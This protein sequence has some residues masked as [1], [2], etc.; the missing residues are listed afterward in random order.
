[1]RPASRFNEFAA[2]AALPLILAATTAYAQSPSS[3]TAAPPRP[4]ATSSV[5][6]PAPSADMQAVLDAHKSL[7]P[8]PI[9]SLPPAEA[10]RQPTPADAV[11]VVMARQHRSTAP[12]PG[13]ST[14]D[15]MYPA[16]Q[17]MQK[18]RIYM[19]DA[20]GGKGPLPVIV[21][22]HGGGWVIAD[23]QAYDATPRF[24]CKALNA[25]VVSI[26]YRHAPEAK[27][28]AQ[29]DDANAAYE[30]VAKNAASWGGD[31]KRLALAGESAGGNLAVA[32]AVA[33]RDHGWPK[34]VHILSV[35]PIAQSDMNTPSYRQ[36][37]SGKP[38][39]SKQ[40]MAWFTYYVV[41]DKAQAKDPR[42]SIVDADLR[43][44]PPV[45]IVNA[46]IDPL[47][48]DGAM[49]EA[50]LRKAGVPVERRVFPG[51]THEFFGMGKVVR[52]ALDAEDYAAGRMRPA[53]QVH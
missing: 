35:Y 51:V 23:V 45:T 53:L 22:Y 15:L 2:V 39:L 49:L 4:P 29:H 9:Y 25:I 36:N 19:P 6:R 18:A 21:Y 48:D 38:F 14:R 37:A 47:R 50:S 44:L 24:L 11:K 7:K 41:S 12:D 40:D 27:F 32:V 16:G 10:R 30:W 20:A 8:K 34:P 13:V 28:P 52:G 31:P 3:A 17:G 43:D 46:D 26:E 5:N 33:A 42:I 1:M